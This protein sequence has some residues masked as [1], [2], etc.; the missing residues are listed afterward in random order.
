MTFVSVS[1]IV[2]ILFLHKRRFS[3]LTSAS[4]GALL[5]YIVYRLWV[6]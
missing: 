4:V 1:G 6:H 3:G 2:L 5:C